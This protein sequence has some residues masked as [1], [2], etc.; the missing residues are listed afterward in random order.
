VKCKP[1]DGDEVGPSVEVGIG[2]SIGDE[3]GTI[4][5]VRIGDSMTGD[6]AG[7]GEGD[8]VGC[9]VKEVVD[10]VVTGCSSK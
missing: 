1:K 10:E 3:M 8:G 4:E 2:D 6:D 5:E 9:E 7:A